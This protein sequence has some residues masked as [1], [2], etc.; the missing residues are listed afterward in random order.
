[1]IDRP[2]SY[3]AVIICLTEENNL[4]ALYL[5]GEQERIVGVFGLHSGVPARGPT[6]TR[7]SPRSSTQV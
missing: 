7:K 4:D 5:L 3:P 2:A 1:M 6:E